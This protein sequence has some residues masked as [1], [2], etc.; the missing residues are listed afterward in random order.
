MTYASGSF[1]EMV[2]DAARE[3]GRSAPT[4]AD[5]LIKRVCP[6][7]TAAAEEEGVLH[8]LRDGMIKAIKA[9]LKGA[10]GVSDG[11]MDFSEL[12][13]AFPMAKDLKSTAYYVESENEEVPLP[14]LV[15]DPDLL[16]AAAHYMQKKGMECLEESRRLFALYE[17]VIARRRP[18]GGMGKPQPEMRP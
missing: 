15:D 12:F 17:A 18:S 10:G 1:A 13:D 7:T 3:W 11:T 5:K 6:R 14:D 9:I 8:W 4:I 16:L 2:V